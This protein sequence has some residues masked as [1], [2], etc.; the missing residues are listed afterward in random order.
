VFENLAMAIVWNKDRV[1]EGLAMVGAVR[2]KAIETLKLLMEDY[3]VRVESAQYLDL[4]AGNWV[5]QL[6]HVAYVAYIE[7]LAYEVI[8]AS[9]PS[10]VDVYLGAY[11]QSTLTTEFYSDLRATVFALFNDDRAA[12]R[13]VISNEVQLVAAGG[14]QKKRLITNLV[15]TS[16]PKVIFCSPYFKCEMQTWLASLW[17]WRSWARW[18]DMELQSSLVIPIDAQWRN[19]RSIAAGRVANFSDLVRVLIPLHVPAVL[20]EGFEKFR[21]LTLCDKKWR[22]RVVYTA[23]A[24][25]RNMA[26]KVRVAEWR[27]EG[28]ILASH[29]HG[30]GYGLD[31][32]FFLEEYESSVADRFYSWGW[33]RQDR[34]VLPLSPAYP[35]LH[36]Q[37][38]RTALLVCCSPPKTTYRLHYAPLPG[39]IEEVVR[40][41]EQLIADWPENLDLM[42]RLHHGNDGHLYREKWQPLHPK[43]TFD[44]NTTR[45]FS[46]FEQ[47]ALIVHNYVGTAFLET[48]AY[49]IPT[50]ALFHEVYNSFRDE[51][52]PLAAELERVGILHRS[53]RAAAKFIEG[54]AT[55]I[56]GWWLRS[57]VQQ[58]R[59]E[60]ASQQA[61]FSENWMIEWESELGQLASN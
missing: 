61:R 8:T 58:A 16:K 36:R 26:F 33:S 27:L 10:R 49:N 47:C 6:L 51:V 32:K 35:T 20:L 56:G 21:N 40:S 52:L 14:P 34:P 46:R 44:R 19:S 53:G 38:N 43:A 24:L 42:I 37:P 13:A 55:D 48:M 17:R 30:C 11:T 9:R 31:R 54:L 39:T 7:S 41:T 5:D 29:Q 28:S 23:N 25:H 3:G 2:P 4:I 22:P 60:F 18:D 57:D 45:I 12:S 50:V 1:G 15:G 59:L